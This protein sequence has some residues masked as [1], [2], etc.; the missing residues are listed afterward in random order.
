MERRVRGVG[1]LSVEA[2][3]APKV[4]PHPERAGRFVVDV[5]AVSASVDGRVVLADDVRF[6]GISD[7]FPDPN[8]PVEI[9]RL[10]PDPDDPEGEPVEAVERYRHD[11]DAVIAGELA[12]LAE[13]KAG[14][15]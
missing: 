13:R 9:V 12:W 6:V 1:R 8:G 15:A 2:A 3:A 4:A 7:L 14:Q 10:V 11:L 5:P